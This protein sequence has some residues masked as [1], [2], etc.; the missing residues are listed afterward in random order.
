VSNE[1]E[2]A[3]RRLMGLSGMF[4]PAGVLMGMGIGWIV[5]HLVPGMF[6]GIGAGMFAMAVVYVVASLRR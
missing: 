6:I 5:G 1:N 2:A 3:R 4:I